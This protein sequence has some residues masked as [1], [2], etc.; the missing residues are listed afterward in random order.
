MSK[1]TKFYSLSVPPLSLAGEMKFMKNWAWG[2]RA[3]FKKICIRNQKR[4]GR[5]NVKVIGS[6][7]FFIFVFS[8]LPMVVTNT[9]SRKSSL[10][11]LFL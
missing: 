8:L 2:G 1:H 4:K 9:V 7:D 3:N 10:E 11:D 5:G 6:C